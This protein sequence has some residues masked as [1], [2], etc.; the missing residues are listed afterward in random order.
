MHVDGP[1]AVFV[2]LEKA[3]EKRLLRFHAAILVQ[4]HHDDVAANF[5]CP[6]PRAVA[7]DED[8]M[9]ILARKHFAGVEA[10]T[11]G[12]GVGAEQSDR[13][14]ELVARTSP[15]QL[16]IGEVPLMA[17]REAEM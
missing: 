5:F 10:H 3:G 16:A 13:L 2:V 4:L 1:T 8:G 17:V 12:S 15:T 6:V 7:G 11:E 14:F 9:L